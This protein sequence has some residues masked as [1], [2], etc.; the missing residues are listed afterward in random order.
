[1]EFVLTQQDIDCT[2]P[3]RFGIMKLLYHLLLEVSN[4]F[5]HISILN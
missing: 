4:S 2:G 3:P 5:L 1:M